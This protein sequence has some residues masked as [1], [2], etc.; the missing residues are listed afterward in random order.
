MKVLQKLFFITI[1]L[2]CL[3]T[4][5]AFA[6]CGGS[7]PNLIAADA[8]R[9]EVAACVNKAAQSGDTITIP[10]GSA[11]WTSPTVSSSSRARV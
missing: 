6:A 1:L 10:A 2:T 8:S 4:A 3:F 9:T 5:E 7:S 11:S